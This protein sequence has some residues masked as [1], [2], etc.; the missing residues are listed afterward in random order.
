MLVVGMLLVGMLVVVG[1]A[2]LLPD[3]TVQPDAFAPAAQEPRVLAA[4]AGRG[5][6]TAA[7]RAEIERVVAGAGSPS[8]RPPH[9]KP[10]HRTAGR[11]PGTLRDVGGPAL[12]PRRRLDDPHRG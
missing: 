8:A 12:L 9:R 10:D 7:M 3:A 6:L 1:L 5:A 4:T 2:P 11:G